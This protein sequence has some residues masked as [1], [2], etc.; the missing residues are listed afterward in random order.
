MVAM[1][2]DG[3]EDRI[4]DGPPLPRDTDHL[5]DTLIVEG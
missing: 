3:I 1:V 4:L 5:L 2:L